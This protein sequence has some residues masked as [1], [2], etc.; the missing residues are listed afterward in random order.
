[1]ATP[2]RIVPITPAA[3]AAQPRSTAEKTSGSSKYSSA[4]IAR[5]ASADSS[6]LKTIVGLVAAATII[7][8][9]AVLFV[10]NAQNSNKG[11]FN[12]GLY[13]TSIE[14]ARENFDDGKYSQSVSDS[15]DAI[16]EARKLGPSDP[17][18]GKALDVRARAYFADRKF[19]K[20]EQDF[21]QALAQTQAIYGDNALQSADIKA[22]LAG[23]MLAT[24]RY[25][26][27]ESLLQQTLAVQQ[28]LKAKDADIAD[29]KFK[30]ASAH[31][32]LHRVQLAT[33]ESKQALAVE[34][35]ALPA[36]DPKLAATKQLVD[37]L[38]SANS[39][40]QTN[41]SEKAVPT[42]ATENLEPQEKADKPA[43]VRSSRRA[44]SHHQAAPVRRRHAYSTYGY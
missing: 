14:K 2:P 18:L 13:S 33:E 23:L 27:A 28:A 22:E 6:N 40:P 20:S 25:A 7:L 39:A 15:T 32:H 12:R 42:V 31:T 24:G 37:S 8:V 17:E 3:P 21:N 43:P 11:G 4:P 44:A 1:V 30:L 10:Q 34:E 38:A 29:T 41:S 5:G 19:D 16:A 35:K 26:Q 36:N 9:G